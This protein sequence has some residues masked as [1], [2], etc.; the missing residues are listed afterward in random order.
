MF[1]C[2]IIIFF[3]KL[4][5]ARDYTSEGARDTEGHGTHTAS[6]AAGNAVADTSFFGIG[7]GTARGGVPAS[8][9]AAYKVC[10][11][12]GCSSEALLSAFDDA[13][14]DGVDLITISIGGKKASM[15]ESDPIAIGAF[16]AMAKGILTVT[17]AGNSGPQDST[18]SSVAPWMLTVAASTTDR[19]FVTKVVLGNNKTLVVSTT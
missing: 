8:R 15:F 13:I 6:T 4:I 19:S 16:H 2:F 18:T 14:A 12:T 10:I 7:N 9:I 3:S 17:A 11:P 5:G 1:I